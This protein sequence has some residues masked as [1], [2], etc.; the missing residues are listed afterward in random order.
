MDH[1]KHV[2]T[3]SPYEAAFGICRA[4]RTGNMIAITGTAPL[5]AAGRTVGVGDVVIQARRCLDIIGSA[6]RELGADLCHVYRT[7]ILLTRIEDWKAVGQV[8]GEFFR[9]VRPASTFAQV[10]GFIDPDWLIEI[11]ADAMLD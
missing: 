10:S 7:R 4:V 3:G 5:D 1:R 6:L 8:H 11:E 2:F 9:D